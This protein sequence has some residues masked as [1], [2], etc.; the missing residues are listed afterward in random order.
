M[1]LRQ[2]EKSSAQPLVIFCAA[3]NQPVLEAIRR[4]YEQEYGTPLQIQYGPSQTLLAGLEVSGA[5][6]LYLP[7]DDSYLTVGPRAKPDGRGVSAG[8]HA[9]RRRRGEGKSQE[10]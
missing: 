9:G 10:D 7:A 8:A 4:D 2:A 6:D 1:S 3:S 5:G